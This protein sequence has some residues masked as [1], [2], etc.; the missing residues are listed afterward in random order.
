M[1][2]PHTGAWIETGISPIVRSLEIKSPLTQG[3]GLKP[4]GAV[5]SNK[6]DRVAPH[7]GAW[8]ETTQW[9]SGGMGIIVA[10]HTGAWIETSIRAGGSVSRAMSPLTQGRGLKHLLFVLQIGCGYVAPHTGAW[11]E[12]A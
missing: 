2:A 6:L 10:P 3:R 4:L 8:I 12:T 1:V 11:I 7:T 9:R 5:D